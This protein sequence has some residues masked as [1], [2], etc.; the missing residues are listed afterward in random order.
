MSES[1]N[2][3]KAIFFLGAGASIKAGIPAV[4]PMTDKFIQHVQSQYGD[5][6]QVLI[7]IIE[8]FKKSFTQSKL[9]VES[10]LHILDELIDLND[11]PISS[12]VSPIHGI[13][14][15]KLKDLKAVLE[16]FIRKQ[17][18]SPFNVEYLSPLLDP[19]W[20]SPIEIFSVNY[21]TCIELLCRKLQRRVI[22]GFTPEWNPRELQAESA[23]KNGVY[24]YKLHG[25]VLWYR[26]IDGW[27]VKIPI[28]PEE[29]SS[30]DPSVTL[31]DGQP[32]NP[33][34]LYPAYKRP[35]ESPL[36]DFTYILKDR[37]KNLRF[38]VVIGYSFRDE[39]LNILFRDAF[40]A[41]PNLR[42]IL[43]SPNA[44]QI[45]LNLL[46]L[47]PSYKY[48]FENR[49]TCCPFPVEKFL[50][51]FTTRQFDVIVGAIGVWEKCQALE[52]TGRFAPWKDVLESL[53]HAG[54]SELFH[55]AARQVGMDALG[56]ERALA[57]VTKSCA[58]S[59][60][61]GDNVLLNN[62]SDLLLETLQY[63]WRMFCAELIPDGKGWLLHCYFKAPDGMP[64]GIYRGGHVGE[65]GIREIDRVIHLLSQDEANYMDKRKRLENFRE[66]IL[67]LKEFF[68][69]F[70]QE[71]LPIQQFISKITFQI[72]EKQEALI[73]WQKSVPENNYQ[74]AS[75]ISQNLRTI[76]QEQLPKVFVDI[77]RPLSSSQA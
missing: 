68:E 49:A 58:F 73:D 14:K 67:K 28:R 34:L 8:S 40:A 50:A 61:L 52:K 46:S 29:D 70:G 26:S 31:Y 9:D 36:L 37:L 76:Y 20:G 48:A 38:I 47:G 77:M 75:D 33:V 32:A 69:S 17:V 2:S 22:D 65:E 66:K 41:N 4:G 18:I 11:Q 64:R 63:I 27:I 21:D 30:Q 13:D 3:K 72:P 44:R 42:M 5:L 35:M 43:I 10:L 57:N 45:Y 71:K 12:F 55:M 25:S 60:A 19:A 15:I 74:Q 16:S 51:E 1:E 56:A 53:A 62:M 23:D 6:H 54:E 39:Y 24:L 59:I 7:K